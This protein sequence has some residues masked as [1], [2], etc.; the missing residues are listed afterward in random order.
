MSSG[1]PRTHGGKTLAEY[2]MAPRA[3]AIEALPIRSRLTL[4]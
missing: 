2:A 1:G 4:P 3:E